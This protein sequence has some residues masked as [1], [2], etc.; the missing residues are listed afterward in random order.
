[1]Q[2]RILQHA[3]RCS[4]IIL[5]GLIADDGMEWYYHQL[6]FLYAIQGKLVPAEQIFQRAVAGYQIAL[7]AE[8]MATLDVVNNLGTSIWSRASSRGLRRFLTRRQAGY[9]RVRRLDGPTL[10]C[11]NRYNT[12]DTQGPYR[13][14]LVSRFLARW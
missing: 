7:G 10:G 8:N 11:H 1:M 5:Q 2:R 12:T 3:A 13:L 9:I 6:G 14:G 4:D